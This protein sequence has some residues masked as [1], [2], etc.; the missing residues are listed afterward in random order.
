LSHIIIIIDNFTYQDLVE[1]WKKRT[2]KNSLEAVHIKYCGDTSKMI[3][4][5]QWQGFFVKK[6]IEEIREHS[7]VSNH[8]HN[9][10]FERLVF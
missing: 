5:K 9:I 10:Q 1:R 2:C 3:L 4:E 6:S 7:Q 8:L